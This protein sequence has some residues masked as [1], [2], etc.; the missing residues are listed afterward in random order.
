MSHARFK[1]VLDGKK[2]NWA[3]WRWTFYEYVRTFETLY[4]AFSSFLDMGFEDV[5]QIIEARN[6]TMPTDQLLKNRYPRQHRTRDL[7]RILI[8]SLEGSAASHIRSCP[9]GDTYGMWLKLN[10]DY[11]GYGSSSALSDDDDAIG[12]AFASGVTMTIVI[13]DYD[14]IF[15]RLA[16]KGEKLADNI[17]CG[18]L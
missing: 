9:S 5:L 16:G 3:D 13:S 6:A 12:Y 2:N 8:N 14:E 11:D 7:T 10:K 1:G 18:F 17:K 15:R 4:Y